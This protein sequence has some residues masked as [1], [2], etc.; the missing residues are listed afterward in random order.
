M[1]HHVGF[2]KLDTMYNNYFITSVIYNC[3]MKIIHVSEFNECKKT[4]W[5]YRS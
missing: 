5:N 1:Q 2:A 4:F 3:Y